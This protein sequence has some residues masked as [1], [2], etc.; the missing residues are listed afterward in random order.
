MPISWPEVQSVEASRPSQAGKPDETAFHRGC[1]LRRACFSWVTGRKVPCRTDLAA[2][3]WPHSALVLGFRSVRSAIVACDLGTMTDHASRRAVRPQG[4][5]PSLDAFLRRHQRSPKR[6][7]IS[8]HTRSVHTAYRWGGCNTHVTQHRNY[9]AFGWSTADHHAHVDT[10]PLPRIEIRSSTSCRAYSR[11]SPELHSPE[12]SGT[13]NPTLGVD[14]ARGSGALSR[15]GR[16]QTAHS[17][18]PRGYC[19]VSTGMLARTATE[20]GE[21]CRFGP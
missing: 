18:S 11:W 12:P 7:T 17:V 2:R 20:A 14:E 15:Y 1:A 4:P 3:A 19:T 16:V 13:G 10:L 21:C 9:A 6:R 5:L 8:S